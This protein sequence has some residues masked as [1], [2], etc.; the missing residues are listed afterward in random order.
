[1]ATIRHLKNKRMFENV[2]DIICNTQFKAEAQ[3]EMTQFLKGKKV[4]WDGDKNII[5][6]GKHFRFQLITK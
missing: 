3:Q 4:E 5:T 2:Y 1:M 6:I